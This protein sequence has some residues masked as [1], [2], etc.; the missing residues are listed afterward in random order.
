MKKMKE[1]PTR[2]NDFSTFILLNMGKE[3]ELKLGSQLPRLLF[4][5]SHCVWQCD[6]GVP[7]DDFGGLFPYLSASL[8]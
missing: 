4:S 2:F 3:L 7:T 1:N 6:T 5:V 8:N